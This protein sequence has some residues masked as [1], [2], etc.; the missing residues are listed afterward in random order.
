MLVVC[1]GIFV[2]HC[3][4]VDMQVVVL[5]AKVPQIDNCQKLHCFV[6]L[7]ESC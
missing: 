6:A 1:A 7:I 3:V 4:N 5:S 2:V